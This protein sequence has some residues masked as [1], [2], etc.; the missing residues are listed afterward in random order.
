MSQEI[1]YTSAPRG[2]KPGSRGFCT[3]VSTQGMAKNLAE[4][5]ES[6]SGY[7]QVFPPQDPKAH[8]N[9]VVHSHLRLSVGGRTLHVLSRI[10]AHGL[11]YTQ[12]ANKFAHHVVLD[13]SEL[14]AAGPAWLISA[15]GFLEETWDGEPRILAAGRKP[16]TGA[17][18][19]GICQAWRQ[20]AGDAGWGGVL[21][22]T[23][24]DPV[25]QAVIVFR[26]GMEM[27]PLL[28]ESLNLLPAE[29]RWGITFSTYFTKLPPG[30][31]CKWRCM[32]E[33]TPEIL[34]ARRSPHITVI[35]LCRP[36]VQPPG[37]WLMEAA[38]TGVVVAQKAAAPSAPD[39]E[40]D[41][42]AWPAP[43]LPFAV[44]SG[45]PQVAAAGGAAAISLGP[46]PLKPGATASRAAP[47]QLRTFKKKR[48]RRWPLVLA[49]T[50]F[51]VALIGGGGVAGWMM[52]RNAT[53]GLTTGG[54]S[55]APS[56]PETPT[57]ASVG[58]T[59]E[60]EEKPQAN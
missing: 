33:G 48:K 40:D 49:C 26:P 28:V 10:S 43:S 18:A 37:A 46:P 6:L 13:P 29:S 51:I 22:E 52:Q 54:A 12:R 56:K 11:D 15:P 24:L 5:L 14:P 8:W 47:P 1:I 53:T 16:P 32:L 2:L 50:L 21:A 27:L 45:L 31:D 60:T 3:V 35:D 39:S 19:A 41:V 36:A 44:A 17:A 23:A 55:G 59:P 42:D 58:P 30:V 20:L 38:R 7:R 4:R 34:A 57:K 9:P 25:R